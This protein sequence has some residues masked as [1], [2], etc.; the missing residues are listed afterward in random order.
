ML[1]FLPF[2]QLFERTVHTLL[3]TCRWPTCTYLPETA[4]GYGDGSVSDCGSSPSPILCWLR[5]AVGSQSMAL[6]LRPL[7]MP[8]KSQEAP[9]SSLCRL[10]LVQGDTFLYTR[11]QFSPLQ[12]WVLT[13]VPFSALAFP[14]EC[15]KPQFR[16][17]SNLF[18]NFVLSGRHDE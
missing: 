9:L 7:Q 8:G 12:F 11:A 14:L 10:G 4:T 3:S 6:W 18:K 17:R 13:W 15:L 5:P 1:S 16:E 2:P